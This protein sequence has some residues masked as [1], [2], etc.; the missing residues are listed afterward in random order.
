MY[1]YYRILNLEPGVDIGQVKK[2]FRVSAQRYHPD[3]N[4]GV[5]NP[6]KF[7]EV[8]KAYRCLQKHYEALN[9]KHL[10]N[11]KSAK[12]ALRKNFAGI[13]GDPPVSGVRARSA[14]Y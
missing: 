2:A 14:A 9:A 12:V 8:V 7:K 13:F 6:E 4:G 1:K 11:E 5:G 3:A 10:A